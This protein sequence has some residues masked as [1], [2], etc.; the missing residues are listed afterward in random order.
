MLHSLLHR[1][2]DGAPGDPVSREEIEFLLN[3]TAPQDLDILFRAAAGT[4]AQYFGNQIFLY[5]FL[6]FSTFCRNNC[7][8][9]QYRRANTGLPRYRKTPEEIID[10]AERM[11]G[12]GVHL[13]DLT[14]GE[15]PAWHENGEAGF[16]RLAELVEE[17]HKR[18]GLPVMVSPGVLPEVVLERLAASGVHWYACYQET[19]T[20][21]LYT[22]LRQG[23]DFD[24]RIAR[25]HQARS[26]GILVEEGILT[27]V[28]ETTADI[29]GSILWM[30]DFGV[31]Q[32]RVMT[33]VPQPGTP[34]A[35]LPGRDNL[36]ELVTIAVM[37]LVL[38]DCLIPASL[39][40]DG[41]DGLPARLSAGANVVTSIVPPEQGLAGVANR[42]L[43]IEESRRSLDTILPVIKG[44][45]LEA[46]SADDYLAW[47][48]R[49]RK[50]HFLK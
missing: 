2:R 31:D 15:D 27:G 12:S 25:K 22:D 37:R 4:R 10:A 26:A 33:F 11:A 8:F 16:K 38:R 24:T 50:S 3:L 17:V 45:G 20:P 28:G 40:V 29:A 48:D 47:A 39:D 21:A 36:R 14:M 41:L 7:R 5:G 42:S 43:D 9:C 49:R 13:I 30:R 23:Q 32:A 1:L 35:G 44:C 34:M 18:T 19:H 46:A 6:Y